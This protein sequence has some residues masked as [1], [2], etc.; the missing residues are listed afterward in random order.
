MNSV[1]SRYDFNVLSI[2]HNMMTKRHLST[3]SFYYSIAIQL[4]IKG[5][6]MHIITNTIESII[7]I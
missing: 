1:I 4:S 2:E 7:K 5:Y 6:K 3:F